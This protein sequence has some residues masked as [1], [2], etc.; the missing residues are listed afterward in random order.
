MLKAINKVHGTNFD[1]NF[2]NSM[3]DYLVHKGY[4]SDD[5]T[6][7]GKNRVY[8]LMHCLANLSPLL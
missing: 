2:G 5:L 3:I 1:P 8:N 4:D 7:M 6:A